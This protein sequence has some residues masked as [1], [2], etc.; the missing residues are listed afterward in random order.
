L[1]LWMPV[2]SFAAYLAIAIYYLVPRGVD[3]DLKRGP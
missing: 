1:A 3:A 2:L